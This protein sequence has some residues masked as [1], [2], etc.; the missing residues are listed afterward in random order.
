VERLAAV[1]GVEELLTYFDWEPL[2]CS[3]S[4]AGALVVSVRPTTEGAVAH[5]VPTRIGAVRR[6]PH[7]TEGSQI[8]ARRAVAPFLAR[9]RL[10][11]IGP[12][13][14]RQ[15]LDQPQSSMPLAQRAPLTLANAAA[16]LDRFIGDPGP[17]LTVQ[18]GVDVEV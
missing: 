1:D 8:T 15:L 14:S 18:D 17:L 2:L 7:S 11:F 13:S 12:S 10:G 6:L 4:S 16:E 9:S 3:G 5:C